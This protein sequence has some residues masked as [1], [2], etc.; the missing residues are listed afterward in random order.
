MTFEW[1]A[2]YEV[3]D[4]SMDA[5][6]HEFVDCVWALLNAPDDAIASALERFHAHAVR[7]FGEEDALMH[8]GGYASAEC[9]L[10]EHKA[11]LA[12]VDEV[13]ALVAD[14]NVAVARSLA[15]EL[16]R[17]FPEHT[18]AMDKGLAAWSQKQR[19]GG[20]AIRILP[21]A[22]AASDYSITGDSKQ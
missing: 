14:G 2:E 9:H 13:R 18:V 8:V 7:H 11:V 1:N 19:L 20:Q 22:Y 17:W 3:G 12:S 10:D 4:A 5:A 15:R 21:R 16:A 6:H